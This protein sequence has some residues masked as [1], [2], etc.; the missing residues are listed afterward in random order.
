VMP[1]IFVQNKRTC[2]S[3]TAL[4]CQSDNKLQ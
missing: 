4:I 1:S 2:L 3:L